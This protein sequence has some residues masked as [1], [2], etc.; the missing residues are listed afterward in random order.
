MEKTND[1]V[2]CNNETSTKEESLFKLADAFEFIFTL[3]S[4][5]S[6]LDYLLPV[7]RK[8]SCKRS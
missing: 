7:T 1:T 4:A 8:P 2:H 6:I 3:V 5:L